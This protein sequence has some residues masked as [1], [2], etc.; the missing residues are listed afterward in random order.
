VEDYVRAGELRI[1]FSGMTFIGE[2]SEKALRT[3]LAAGEQNRLWNVVDLLYLNQ[4]AENGGW[5]TDDLLVAIGRSVP[6]LD[7]AAMLEAAGSES[8]DTALAQHEERA[9]AAGITSTPSF[10]LGLTGGELAP[11]AVE[12]LDAAEFRAAIDE[13]L[14]R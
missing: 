6:G 7:G 10:Q 14:E 3:A 13:L 5:V 12:S 4:G 2:E 8:V 1:E 9:G 11:L